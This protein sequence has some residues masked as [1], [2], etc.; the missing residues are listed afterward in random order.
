M[1]ASTCLYSLYPYCTCCPVSLRYS[2]WKFKFWGYKFLYT[3]CYARDPGP[4]FNFEGRHAPYSELAA[5]LT[6]F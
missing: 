4:C 2:A 5:F 1:L 6:T 3:L